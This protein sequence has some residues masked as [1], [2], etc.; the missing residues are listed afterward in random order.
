MD[1]GGDR[2]GVLVTPG[3]LDADQLD[4]D[5]LQEGV[6]LGAAVAAAAHTGLGEGHVVDVVGR[7]SLAA[8][9][10]D[11]DPLDERVDRIGVVAPTEPGGGGE[12]GGADVGGCQS[13]RRPA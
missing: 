6:H 2:R 3:V 5:A 12:V 7:E 11:R 1:A 4:V 9:Q 10:S 13:H 8:L